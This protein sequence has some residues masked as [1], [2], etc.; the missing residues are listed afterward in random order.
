L[1]ARFHSLDR[2][3]VWAMIELDHG[4][5]SMPGLLYFTD[6]GA[7]RGWMTVVPPPPNAGELSFLDDK[8]GFL[9]ATTTTT[10]LPSLW[11]TEDGGLSWN[12]IFDEDAEIT[13]MPV[14]DGD[15]AVIVA[16]EFQSTSDRGKTWRKG[17]AL[18]EGGI[19]GQHGHDVLRVADGSIAGSHAGGAFGTPQASALLVGDPVSIAVPT[20]ATA[21]VVSSLPKSTF[22]IAVTHDGARHWTSF[23]PPPE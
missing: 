19:L 3:R 4:M 8:H 12:S 23:A 6:D 11:R 18:P 1:G 9:L 10:S 17:V 2:D 21:W 14:F 5:S 7:K 22:R 13:A 20:Y 15:D 16:K